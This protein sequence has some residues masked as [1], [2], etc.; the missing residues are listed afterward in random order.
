MSIQNDE[1]FISNLLDNN[2]NIVLNKSLIQEF[3]L[4]E[5]VVYGELVNR[6]LQYKRDNLLP[7]N[8]MFEYS[9]G[10]LLFNTTIGKSQ[11]DLC[12]KNLKNIGLIDVYEKQSSNKFHLIRYFKVLNPS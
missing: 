3:G 1:N 10:E 12:I 11:Q 8:E 4:Y 7:D 5:A 2:D 6:Y 9:T